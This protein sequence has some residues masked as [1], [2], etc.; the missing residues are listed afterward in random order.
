[1][2]SKPRGEAEITN[3]KVEG[4]FRGQGGPNNLAACLSY[5][6]NPVGHVLARDRG[7]GL[8]ATPRLLR[9]HLRLLYICTHFALL[10]LH[11]LSTPPLF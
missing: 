5:L 6:A 7:L 8:S 1:M 9:E 4:S 3:E 11:L 2:F 10:L